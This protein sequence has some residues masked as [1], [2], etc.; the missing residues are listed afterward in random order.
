MEAAMAAAREQ[1]LQWTAAYGYHAAVPALLADPAGV[2]WAWV[3][4]LLL[5]GKAGKSVPLLLL[6]GVLI[7]CA[8]DHA[9]YWLG[10]L[11][12]GGLVPRL[13]RRFPKMRKGLDEAEATVRENA[14]AAILLGRYLPLVGRWVGVGAGLACVPYA[15]FAAWD[16]GGAI[17]TSVGFG[18]A[19]HLAG[20][21]ILDAPWFPQAVLAAFAIGT[22]ATLA[23]A[24]WRRARRA[25]NAQEQDRVEEQRAERG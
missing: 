13:C 10:R 17:L 25:K 18:L 3:F 4:L 14:A 6:Y 20:H 11:G 15:R 9:L 24:L 23:V 7:V 16:L 5:A 2:P 21:A 22:G 1:A 8:A 19:A 12:R